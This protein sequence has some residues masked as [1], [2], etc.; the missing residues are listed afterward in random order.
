MTTLYI[1]PL[2]FIDRPTE[3]GAIIMLT[4]PEES[5]SLKLATPVTPVALQPSTAGRGQNPGRNNRRRI[6]DSHVHQRRGPG[7]YQVAS[8]PGTNA[9]GYAGVPSTPRLL[10]TGHEPDA[11]PRPGTGPAKARR[12]VRGDCQAQGPQPWQTREQRP[13]QGQIEHQRETTPT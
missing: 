7:G 4:N 5:T 12:R 6:C 2:G 11:Y 13:I 3:D 8:K 10:R 1:M 9:P